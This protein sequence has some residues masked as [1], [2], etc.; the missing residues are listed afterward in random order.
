M[1]A[2]WRTRSGSPSKPGATQGGN[3][4]LLRSGDKD[5]NV[6]IR[7]RKR[8]EQQQQ[9]RGQQMQEDL[10]YIEIGEQLT[11]PHDKVQSQI[12]IYGIDR[13]HDQAPTRS[14]SLMS[15]CKAPSEPKQFTGEVCRSFEANEPYQH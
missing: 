11:G 3:L 15:D 9:L 4:R 8:H 12:D 7:R 10:A 2:S 6:S 13:D 5:W 14:S 1:I